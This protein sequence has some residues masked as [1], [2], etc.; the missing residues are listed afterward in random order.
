MSVIGDPIPIKRTDGAPEFD[1]IVSKGSNPANPLV[2]TQIGNETFEANI[3][4]VIVWVVRSEVAG[5]I[6]CLIL[7][8]KDE[9]NLRFYV[10]RCDVFI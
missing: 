5:S 2:N 10:H 3:Q 1:A 8:K 9:K 7:H 6:T 4:T